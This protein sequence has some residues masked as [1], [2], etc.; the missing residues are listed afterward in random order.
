MKW[1]EQNFEAVR[2]ARAVLQENGWSLGGI[3]HISFIQENCPTLSDE[4]A[5]EILW[6]AQENEEVRE[7]VDELATMEAKSYGREAFDMNWDF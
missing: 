2:Q 7:L 6:D 1:N 4:Q 3:I 5:L